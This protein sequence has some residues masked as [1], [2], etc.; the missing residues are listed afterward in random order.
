MLIQSKSEKKRKKERKKYQRRFKLSV[1]WWVEGGNN[2]YLTT[3]FINKSNVKLS[4]K[5]RDYK[6]F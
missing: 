6:D 3:R 4:F 1:R 2:D 5:K